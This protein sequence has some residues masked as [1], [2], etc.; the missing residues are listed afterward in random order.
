MSISLSGCS[1]EGTVLD[2]QEPD[3]ILTRQILGVC[4]MGHEECLSTYVD[5]GPYEAKSAAVTDSM[6]PVYIFP[7]RPDIEGGAVNPYDSLGLYQPFRLQNNV[8]AG[9]GR[10]WSM[11]EIHS[12]NLL[13]KAEPQPGLVL[14][15]SG[16]TPPDST[17]EGP[18]P[19]TRDLYADPIKSAIELV[20]LEQAGDIAIVDLFLTTDCPLVIARAE[21]I[22]INLN[23]NFPICQ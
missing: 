17:D 8:F 23:P 6:V 10:A 22:I 19:R 14:W 4:F 3:P 18:P 15:G 16:V 5:L 1:Q 2:K 7:S 11:F 12:R 13:L 9:P 21:D 20:E